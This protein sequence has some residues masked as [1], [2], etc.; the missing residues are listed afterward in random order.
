[1]IEIEG[2]S[3][4]EQSMREKPDAI[5]S[6]VASA[7][8]EWAGELTNY[9]SS[10]QLGGAVLNRKSGNLA[11]SINP[12]DETGGN[13][14]AAGASVSLHDA[15]YAGLQEFGGQTRPHEIVP[16]NAEYL[17]FWWERV[18]AWVKTKHV[19][20][21]GSNMPER[22]FMRSG[23]EDMASSGIDAIRGA[24]REALS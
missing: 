20:H 22:S 12:V 11:R 19:N 4:F 13:P 6:S 3:E 8:R 5:R 7:M 21:P 9:I 10:V 15:P 18:G 16:V 17:S 23:L 24:L 14:M 2:A 1:M